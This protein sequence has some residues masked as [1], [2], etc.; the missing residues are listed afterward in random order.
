MSTVTER[1]GFPAERR[2]RLRPRDD[3]HGGRGRLYRA[4]TIILVLV[5]LLIT[6]ATVYDVVRQVHISDRLHVDLVS[7]EAITGTRDRHA[8][9][10]QDAKTYTTRDVV[11]GKT[12]VLTPSAPAAVCLIFQG[13]VKAGRREA[14]GGYYVLKSGRRKNRVSDKARYRYACFG[15]AAAL[16]FRCTVAAPPGAPDRP[17]PTRRRS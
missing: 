17:L 11:C 5:A 9:V 2:E 1:A 16:G 12:R 4:E 8:I 10:E 6:V 3:D 14:T 13:P 7:W 15:D